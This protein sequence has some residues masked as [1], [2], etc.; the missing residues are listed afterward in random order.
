MTCLNNSQN[1]MNLASVF[2][3][4]GLSARF[5]CRVCQLSSVGQIR[6]GADYDISELID[7]FLIL[8]IVYACAAQF[9]S[10]E[11]TLITYGV[12]ERKEINTAMDRTVAS[13]PQKL[14][15]INTQRWD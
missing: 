15:R 7:C 2:G 4:T 1:S 14:Q 6:T 13:V 9:C 3:I 11:L 12:A 10:A 5:S 8:N